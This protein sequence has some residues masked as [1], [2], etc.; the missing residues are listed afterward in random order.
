M[1]CGYPSEKRPRMPDRASLREARLKVSSTFSKVAGCRGGAL[2]R[3]PQS[4]ELSCA[5]KSAGGGPRGNPRRGFPLLFW[6][7]ACAPFYWAV[8]VGLSCRSTPFLWCLPKETVSSRQR[9]A[10]FYPGGSTIRVSAPA[11]VVFT[12]LRPT[13]GRGGCVCAVSLGRSLFPLLPV[14]PHF[15][16]LAQRNG[17]EPQRNALMGAAT[18][19]GWSRPPLPRTRSPNI[20]ADC[21]KLT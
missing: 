13:L 8:V 14:P 17:V 18:G 16:A 2:A 12:H 15:F 9:K 19:A 11:S 21:V 5:H 10:L 4:A 6:V 20:T 3:A 1:R 7:C